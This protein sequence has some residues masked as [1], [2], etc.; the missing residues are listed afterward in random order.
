MKWESWSERSMPRLEQDRRLTLSKTIQ[1]RHMKWESWFERSMPRPEQDR[2]LTLSK[3]HLSRSTPCPK[4][5]DRRLRPS[6]VQQD[7]HQQPIGFHTTQRTSRSTQRP[8]NPHPKSTKKLEKEK[9]TS[10][11]QIG[12][13]AWVGGVGWRESWSNEMREL[14]SESEVREEMRKREWGES[15][16]QRGE[17]NKY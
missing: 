5:Q 3:T 12:D 1:P 10:N 6:T 11:Q 7:R 16:V 4:Q 13:G 14:I 2:R 8:T 15:E 9:K 17:R